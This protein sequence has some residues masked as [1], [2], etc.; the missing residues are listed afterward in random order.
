MPGDE[1]SATSPRAGADPTVPVFPR[2]F[3]HILANSVSVSLVDLTVWFSITYEVFLNTKSVFASALVGGL[4]LVFSSGSGLWLGSFV[5]HHSTRTAMSA[6]T[7]TSTVLYVISLAL[8]ET[9]SPGAFSSVASPILWIFVVLLLAGVAGGNV[10]TIALPTLVTH[11]IA[12]S[13]RARANGLVGSAIGASFALT[14][15]VSGVLVG[16]GGMRYVLSLGIVVNLVAL[17]HLRWIDLPARRNWSTDAGAPRGLDLRGTI[18][19]V[20]SVPGLPALI[21]FASFNNLLGGVFLALIDPYGL[22]LMSVQAWG[23]L[24]GTLSTG[25]LVG[26]AVIARTGLGSNPLRLLLLADVAM[27]SVTIVFPIRASVPLLAAGIFFTMLLFPI[28]EAA[29]QTVLQ[30][31]VPI[32][33]QGRVFGFALTVEQAAAP[34]TAFLIGPIAE[35]A[36]IPFMTTGAGVDLIGGWFGVGPDRGMALVLIGTAVVG[37]IFT[38]AAMRTRSYRALLKHY[39]TSGSTADENGAPA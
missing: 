26:G 13:H 21:L 36:V 22:S 6:A 15:V 7:A 5:D 28:A 1:R 10:R 24:F 30:R 38:V 16:L 9:A 11:M 23:A 3:V 37:V 34:L 35:F 25:V 17:L 12:E 8:Y 33:R 20:R 14:A 27:W 4:Y 2:P 39:R 19:V 29:E 32:E 18:R 31:V